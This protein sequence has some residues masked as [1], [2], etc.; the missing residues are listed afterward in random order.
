MI[1]G[2]HLLMY[3]DQPDADRAFLRDVLGFPAVDAGHGWLIFGLP[4]A[5]MAVHPGET[6]AQAHAG[7][8]MATAVVYLMCDDVRETVAMLERKQVRCEPLQTAE[9]GI[10]TAF[11]LPSGASMGLYQPTHETALGRR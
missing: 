3:S 10:R 11:A 8:R 7:T 6:A 9:W 5:E 4:P 2:A 1:T